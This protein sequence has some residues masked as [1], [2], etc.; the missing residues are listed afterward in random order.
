MKSDTGNV[1]NNLE[2]SWKS[3]EVFKK[4]LELNLRELQ[5]HETYPEHWKIT[6]S[7]LNQVK[8]SAILDIGCGCGSFFKVCKDN[9][10]EMEYFGCDYS[11]D[12]INLAKE[13]WGTNNFV[14]KDALKLQN[15]DISKYDMIYASALMD[16]SPIGDVMMNHILSLGAGSVLF[17]RVKTTNKSSY[18]EK[19]MAYDEI[20]TCAFYHNINNLVDMFESNGYSYTIVSDHIYGVK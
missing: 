6:L 13:T 12:A 17:S 16:V 9:L 18:Y 5:S 2:D 8:P 7:I 10:P 14:V 11:S 3:P 19:Y 1:E 20:E 15:D 4:Q